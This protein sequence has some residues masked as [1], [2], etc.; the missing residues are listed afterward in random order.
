MFFY[1]I[2]VLD[3]L[4]TIK[5]HTEYENWLCLVILILYSWEIIT[6][7]E[8]EHLINLFVHW[9]SLFFAKL[10]PPKIKVLSYA[11]L[12]STL[13]TVMNQFKVEVLKRTLI[14]EVLSKKSAKL[15]VKYS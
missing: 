11:K 5:M 9:D 3:I 13:R 1:V 4:K 14:F 15:S 2:L 7:Y 6:F 12:I 10:T 8:P